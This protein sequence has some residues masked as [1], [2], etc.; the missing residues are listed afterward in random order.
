MHGVE[1]KGERNCAAKRNVVVLARSRQN[2]SA[3]R[4]G[5][6]DEV[7]SCIVAM[8]G[9]EPSKAA[10]G[11]GDESHSTS[12]RWRLMRRFQHLFHLRLAHRRIERR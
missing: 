5:V 10:Q 11:A 2:G 8:N 4:E 6:M 9:V 1:V 12:S 7:V 3:D